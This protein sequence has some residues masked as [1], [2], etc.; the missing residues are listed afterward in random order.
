MSNAANSS[1]KKHGTDAYFDKLKQNAANELELAAHLPNEEEPPLP[2]ET[3]QNENK[4][5]TRGGDEASEDVI[6]YAPTTHTTSHNNINN[7]NDMA[8]D[9]NGGIFGNE[10]ESEENQIEGKKKENGKDKKES[11]LSSEIASEDIDELFIEYNEN[12]DENG[13]GKT[14]T[15]AGNSTATGTGTG[16]ARAGM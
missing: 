1:S 16:T 3:G 9:K 6:K 10:E 11:G 15:G 12:D 4:I 14:S 8:S 2:L 13:N 5:E 7:K